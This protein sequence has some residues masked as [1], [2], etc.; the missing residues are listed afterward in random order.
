MTQ[1]DAAQKVRIHSTTRGVDPG[2]LR[3]SGPPENM[4]GSEYVLTP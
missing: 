2:G 1:I 3:G 4:L